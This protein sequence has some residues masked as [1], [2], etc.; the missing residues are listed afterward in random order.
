[1]QQQIN[2]QA[3]QT[4]LLSL[5]GLKTLFGDI[6]RCFEKNLEQENCVREFDNQINILMK[7][8]K[9]KNP[10]TAEQTKFIFEELI[11]GFA[12]R[13]LA[14]KTNNLKYAL[15]IADSINLLTNF[16]NFCI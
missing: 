13:V 10:L 9:E 8:E 4:E 5:D 2:G 7:I 6:K 14:L 3:T 1:M 12:K 15:L 11:P 16:F